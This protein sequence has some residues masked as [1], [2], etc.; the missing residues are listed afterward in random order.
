MMTLPP[1]LRCRFTKI[2]SKGVGHIK[3]HCGTTPQFLLDFDNAVI[4]LS[5]S[6]AVLGTYPKG[7]GAFGVAAEGPDVWLTN[8]WGKSVTKLR[9]SDGLNLGTFDVGDGAAGV[10][11]DGTNI[12]IANHGASNLMKIARRTVRLS[13]VRNW[14]GTVFDCVEWWEGFGPTSRPT[15]SRPRQQTNGVSLRG[16]SRRYATRASRLVAFP[17]LKRRATFSSVATRQCDDAN[18]VTPT[19]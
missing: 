9:A 7:K 3:P 19:L 18:S 10:A 16:Y 17:A 6:G 13:D 12:W 8:F 5:L 15:P 1:N 14:E 11:F 4:R 2:V